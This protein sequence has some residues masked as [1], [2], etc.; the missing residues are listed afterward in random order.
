[1]S[2]I[3]RVLLIVVWYSISGCQKDST[4]RS[5]YYFKYTI[6]GRTGGSEGGGLLSGPDSYSVVSGSMTLI[7]AYK[8]TDCNVSNKPPCYT[9]MITLGTLTIGQHSFRTPGNLLLI[10]ENPSSFS[11]NEYWI[12]FSDGVG[13][14]TVTITKIG[15]VGEA[16][17]GTFTGKAGKNTSDSLVNITGRFRLPRTL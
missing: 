16:V 4:S 14:G 12:S 9:G 15:N 7:G 10:T 5:D 6:D 8:L 3:K 11:T 17:E 1:M 13:D 2:W